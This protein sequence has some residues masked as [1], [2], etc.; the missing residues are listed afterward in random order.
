MG[1]DDHRRRYAD[2]REVTGAVPVLERAA[3]AQLARTVH[4]DLDGVVDVVERA[5]ERIGPLGVRHRA[6]LQ[7]A[8]VLVEQLEVAGVAGGAVG[9][10][11]RDRR[12]DGVNSRPER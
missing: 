10:E 5:D 1:R 7:L 2:V 6:P 8:V 4:R 12:E 11:L 9:L 3:H